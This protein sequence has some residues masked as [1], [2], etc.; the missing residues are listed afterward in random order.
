MPGVKSPTDLI[1]AAQM[2]K[3]WMDQKK[4][5]EDKVDVLK[6]KIHEA[7]TVTIPPLMEKYDILEV[8]IEHAGLLKKKPI[9]YASYSKANEEVI[10]EWLRERGDGDLIK[11]TL[12]HRTFESYARELVEENE[13]MPDEIKVHPVVTA[14]LTGKG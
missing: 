11:P 6:T 4:D 8:R 13:P 9:I 5:L 2:L 7:K 12:N 3:R 10:F 14:S 1:V